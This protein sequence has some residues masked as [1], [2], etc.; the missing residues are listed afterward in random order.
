MSNT[1]T[2]MTV[3]EWE[4]KFQPITNPFEDNGWNGWMFE[5]YGKDLEYVMA[6][7][8]NHVWTWVDGDE[9]DDTCIVSGYYIVNRIGYFVT[10]KP[11]SEFGQQVGSKLR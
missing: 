4:D 10:N 2:T 3:D 5:T 6:Q 11:W 1:Q 8:E 9:D 7:P